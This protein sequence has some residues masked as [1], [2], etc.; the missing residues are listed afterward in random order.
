MEALTVLSMGLHK[1]VG[2]C[3][4]VEGLSSVL[5]LDIVSFVGKFDLV[6]TLF[7]ILA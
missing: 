3:V 6:Y 2:G 1:C 7:T 4:F 5:N